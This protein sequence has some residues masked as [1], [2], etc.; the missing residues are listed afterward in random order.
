MRPSNQRQGRRPGLRDVARLANVS[1]ATASRVLSQPEMVSADV[2]E[3]VENAC[4]ELN[5]IANRT[6][7]RL[8]SLRGETMGLILPA[9]GN[10][11]FAPTIDGIRSVLD[12][13]G[14]G[15]FINSAER[16]PATEMRQIRTLMEH[17][18]DAVLTM[19][20]VHLPETYAL[21]EQ[22]GLPVV[23]ITVAGEQP[24]GVSVDYD[25]SGAMREIVRVVLDAGHREIA[26]LSGPCSTSP[27][28][29][30][31]YE[32]ALAALAEA[33]IAPPPEWQVETAYTVP[34]MREGA[35][36]LLGAARRPTA[37]ICTGD[38]HAVATIIEA[39]ALGLSVPG[40][41]S[42]TG[43]NDVE[44]AQLCEP[45]VTTL[46]LPY[47]ALGATAAQHA[48]DLLDA[49]VSVP[50]RTILP[51]QLITRGSVAAPNQDRRP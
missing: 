47:H 30:E 46:R 48:L 17:G 15:L 14:Y 29:A 2:R 24:P 22:A 1:L 31:R 11:L 8:S 4:A 5:Y 33:G 37:V 19:L 32:A 28:I 38:Q 51:H 44:I 43:C 35:R 18:V 25:N 6:A 3:R 12:P 7:R 23:Y 21:I 41:V 10:P 13:R 34:A 45:M 49:E 36:V 20:P 40:D 42:V 27:V 16:D 39:Q 9:I 26:L 50:A